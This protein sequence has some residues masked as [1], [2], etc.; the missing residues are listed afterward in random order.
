[1]SSFRKSND[2]IG[3]L[4]GSAGFS[5]RTCFPGHFVQT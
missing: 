5:E 2:G 3:K 4:G 1:M